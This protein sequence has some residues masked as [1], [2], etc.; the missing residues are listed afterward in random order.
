MFLAVDAMAC[1]NDAIVYSSSS[2]WG[3]SIGGNSGR[4]SGRSSSSTSIPVDYGGHAGCFEQV[5]SLKLKATWNAERLSGKMEIELP[6]AKFKDLPQ[7]RVDTYL[8]LEPR[9]DARELTRVQLLSVTCV[10]RGTLALES[11]EGS[12]KDAVERDGAVSSEDGTHISTAGS[13]RAGSAAS[14]EQEQGLLE[15]W[16][17]VAGS[18]RVQQVLSAPV[19]AVH[20]P[21]VWIGSL[22]RYNDVR[23]ARQFQTSELLPALCST[24]FRSDMHAYTVQES[25]KN[26]QVKGLKSRLS[27]GK[28]KLEWDRARR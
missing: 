20:V 11:F 17:Q 16:V 19:P 22:L 9:E 6:R 28:I 2:G 10:D 7:G 15:R 25:L 27:D 3:I 13:L 4:A 26:L 12:W 5:S 18:A 21:R 8:H 24:E 14:P 1:R 23:I